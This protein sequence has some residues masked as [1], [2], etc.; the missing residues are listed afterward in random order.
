MSK[1]DETIDLFMQ[2]TAD[3][4][5]TMEESIQAIVRQMSQSLGINGTQLADYER[6]LRQAVKEREA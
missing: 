3:S 1:W 4:G 2:K 6:R 5:R